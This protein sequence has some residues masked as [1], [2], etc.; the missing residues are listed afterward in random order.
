MRHSTK[1][2]DIISQWLQRV[3]ALR[4]SKVLSLSLRKPRP[5]FESGIIL[6][7][8][9]YSI[10]HVEAGEPLLLLHAGLGKGLKGGQGQG[11]AT[12][13]AQ[14]A[15]AVKGGEGRGV[16]LFDTG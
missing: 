13:S 7:G 3:E 14:E 8:H 2:S 10:G 6:A 1:D 12:D 16:H 4:E 9:R 15:S 11:K 5:V